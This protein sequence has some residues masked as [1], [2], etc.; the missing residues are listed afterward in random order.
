[1]DRTELGQGYFDYGCRLSVD[2]CVYVCT[3]S[4]W[5]SYS[6]NFK[7][8]LRYLIILLTMLQNSALKEEGKGEQIADSYVL[9][10]SATIHNFYW[11]SCSTAYCAVVPRR[12]S[13]RKWFLFIL[14]HAL[15]HTGKCS[16]HLWSKKKNENVTEVESTVVCSSFLTSL[17][18]CSSWPQGSHCLL[19][20]VRKHLL[21]K[22]GKKLRLFLTGV[23]ISY[24][25]LSLP[26]FQW[27]LVKQLGLAPKYN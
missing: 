17:A 23:L 19:Q 4:R 26:P 11:I 22:G 12:K 10:Q 9:R 2:T 18:F 7:S 13:W 25:F 8:I 1:M 15:Y 20:T 3:R 5:A 6:F 16:Y 27:V 21:K 14:L 24:C